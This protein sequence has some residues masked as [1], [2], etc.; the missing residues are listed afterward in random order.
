[1]GGIL[2]TSGTVMDT[3]IQKPGTAIGGTGGGYSKDQGPAMGRLTH[4]V[5]VTLVG[6]GLPVA[7]QVRT[8]S[9]R[10]MYQLLS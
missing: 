2:Q 4:A 5:Q 1:M 7:W 10:P 8:A 9:V 6:A 3:P